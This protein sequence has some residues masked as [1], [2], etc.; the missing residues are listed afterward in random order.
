MGHPAPASSGITSDYKTAETFEKRKLTKAQ[1]VA[2]LEASFRHLH[3]GMGK[4]T[5]AN[6]GEMIQM[7]GQNWSRLRSMVLTVTHLHEHLGQAIAYA[8]INKVVPPWSK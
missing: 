7:F 6:A 2:E 1:V 5:D 4:T 8:R 3:Q